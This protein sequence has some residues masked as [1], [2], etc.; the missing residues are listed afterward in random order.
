[1]VLP[2]E[3]QLDPRLAGVLRQP[4]RGLHALAEPPGRPAQ[5]ELGVGA[6]S[7][8]DVRA[9]EEHVAELLR[10][11]LVASRVELGAELT[12]LVLEIAERERRIR[13]VEPDGGRTALHLA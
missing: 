6:Q 4:L 1:M 2:V 11:P 12:Q 5:L 8:G 3:R 9:R 7:P 10:L 13:V